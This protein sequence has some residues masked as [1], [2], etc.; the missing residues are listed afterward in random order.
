MTTTSER[1]HHSSFVEQS[2][3]GPLIYLYLPVGNRKVVKCRS[4]WC[5]GIWWYPCVASSFANT[6]DPDGM[7]CIISIA[8]GNGC[9][10]RLTNLLRWLKSVTRRRPAFPPSFSTKNP[11]ETHSLGSSIGTGSMTPSAN[12]FFRVLLAFSCQ[13]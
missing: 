1:A 2:P 5:R 4:A 12:N 9:I 10:G 3:I 11:G 13:W 8:D 7:F 6:F